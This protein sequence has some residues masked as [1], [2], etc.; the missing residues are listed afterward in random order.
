MTP[1]GFAWRS[2]SREPARAVLGV[3]GVA[4]VG[5]LLF[6]MLLLS[7]GLLVSFRDLLQATG[8]DVRVTA[9][10]AMPGTGPMLTDPARIIAELR[11]LPEVG[12]VR[13]V[14]GE[15]GSAPRGDRWLEV[16]VLGIGPEPRTEGRLLRGR[17][18]TDAVEPAEVVVNE[19]LARNLGVEPGATL[20]LRPGRP[21]ARTAVPPRSYRVVGVA[22]FPFDMAGQRTACM[23]LAALRLGQF[24]RDADAAEILLVASRPEMGP[25]AAV[26]AIRRARPDLHAFTIEEFLQRFRQG[27]FSYF[28]QISAV[29]TLVTSFFAFLLV[30]TLLTVSVNQRLG[31]VAALRALGFTRRRVA[32]DL[33]AECALV[34]GTGSLLALPLGLVLAR[35]LDDILRGMPGL[36]ERLHFFVLEPWAVGLHLLLLGV[37][38]LLAAL[39]PVAVA[40]RLPIA[41]TLRREVVS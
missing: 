5:A 11:R 17:D 29:L 4:I 21:D 26:A 13:A 20:V 30:A 38:G 16:T 37:A 36:P 19:T 15:A 8:Y 3:A 35:V 10:P 27:D 22:D 18:L 33:L 31:E 40:V 1:V 39:W 34:V 12:D 7:R 28:R 25:D 41:A 9:S 14:R 2:L 24:G 6:D 32:K 23:S